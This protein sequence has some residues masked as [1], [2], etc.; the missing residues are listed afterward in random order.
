M[1]TSSSSRSAT[2]RAE[3]PIRGTGRDQG[4]G[5][6]DRR[7]RGAERGLRDLRRAHAARHLHGPARVHHRGGPRERDDRVLERSSP[8]RGRI[9]GRSSH[10]RATVGV[11]TGGPRPA[12]ASAHRSAVTPHHRVDGRRPD[13]GPGPLRHQAHPQARAGRGPR[14]GPLR[15]RGGRDDGSHRG[16]DP[17][18][19]PLHGGARQSLGRHPSRAR[20]RARGAP[21]AAGHPDEPHRQDR[22]HPWGGVLVR[23]RCHARRARHPRRLL[24]AGRHLATA[25]RSTSASRSPSWSTASGPT[26]S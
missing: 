25:T 10:R 19:D 15:V 16:R 24:R 23:A 22:P 1:A 14:R 11:R 21:T 13:R 5:P 17:G 3:S 26:R 8:G 12:R 4:G 9:A 6:A 7:G 20:D 2:R 18:R